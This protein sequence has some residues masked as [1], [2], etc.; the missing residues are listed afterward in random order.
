M[1]TPKV[2][3]LLSWNPWMNSKQSSGERDIAMT[4]FVHA[5]DGCRHI[6]A[7]LNDKRYD[8]WSGKDK[9]AIS[10][11]QFGCKRWLFQGQE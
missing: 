6:E 9:N 3:W 2:E 8:V 7:L 11:W 10:L 1:I 5:A 4:D